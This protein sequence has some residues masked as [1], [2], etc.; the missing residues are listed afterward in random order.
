MNRGDGAGYTE[1]AGQTRRKG[2]RQTMQYYPRQRHHP[3]E[4]L[5]D[6]TS[7]SI[8]GKG[9][10]TGKLRRMKDDIMSLYGE[11]AKRN[12]KQS[13]FVP[14]SQEEKDEI[15]QLRGLKYFILT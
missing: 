15:Q 9:R 3:E 2:A 13:T 10:G 14:L 1:G 6:N 11:E 12:R 4:A 8:D 7:T 5:W